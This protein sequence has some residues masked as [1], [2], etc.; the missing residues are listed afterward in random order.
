MPRFDLISEPWIPVRDE[1]GALREVSLEEALLKSQRLIRIEDPSPLVEAALHRLLVAVLHRALQGPVAPQDALELWMEGRFPEAPVRSYLDR[2]RHRFDLFDDTAPFYQVAD[3]PIDDPLPWS[4]LLP[5]L[6]SGNNA[7]LF[8]H[9]TDD[10]LP[11]AP[12]SV[13]AR[14]LLVH[15]AFTPGGLIRRLGVTAGKN[16]PLATAAVFVPLGAN[17][18]E[19]LLFSLVPYQSDGDAPIWERPALRTSDVEGERT[20]EPLFGLTRVYTWMS[21]AV[22]LI[23]EPDGTVLA[24]GY[25][26]GV[27]PVEEMPY[28]DPMCAYVQKET[29][30]RRPVRLTLD[31]AFWRD[32]EALL[33]PD[34]PEE[35][36]AKVPAVLTNARRLLGQ[37]GRDTFILPLAVLGQVTDQA[38]VLAMRREVYPFP[39]SALD[40]QTA[41]FVRSAL[42][43]AE[44]TGQDL[45]AAGLSACNALLSLGGRTPPADEVR[46]LLQSLPLLAHYW[47][48]LEREFVE[49]LTRLGK[50]GDEQVMEQWTSSL[51]R[52]VHQ[53]WSETERALGVGPRHLRAIQAAE[54]RVAA[55]L[56]SLSQEVTP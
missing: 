41:W 13:A 30:E 6:S 27:V 37:R 12:P 4:K 47:S 25:G 21:R 35:A 22:R 56:S 38:K 49:F 1:D 51:R 14:A 52:A 36:V 34:K 46:R 29:V 32:F 17:L 10:R 7:T 11:P 28:S 50:A 31:R 39:L 23:P 44:S 48:Q 15:Q 5:E 33:P 19:T 3:L 53:A 26:P 45:R 16:A 2:F 42:D 20:R 9:T 40:A 55:V 8:D 43:M 18:F 54:R 24:M